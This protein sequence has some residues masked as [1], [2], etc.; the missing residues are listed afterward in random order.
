MLQ[1]FLL[2]VCSHFLADYSLQSESMAI[3][4]GRFDSHYNTVPWYYWM[5]AHCA[6]HSLF[7]MCITH[8]IYYGIIEFVI[9]FLSDYL[10]C[11]RKI[12]I[13]IDQA[14]HIFSKLIYLG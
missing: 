13:H 6:V 4:K 12:N 2:L 1:T 14:I 3:G 10:K 9:H 11:K 5:A 7:V 8:N